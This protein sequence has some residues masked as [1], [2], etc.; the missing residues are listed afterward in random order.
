M[1]KLKS[2][3]GCWSID[4]LILYDLLLAVN[5]DPFYSHVLSFVLIPQAVLNTLS[6]GASL[7]LPPLRERTELLLSLL[8]Q[9][10]QSL[11]ILSKG[12][13]CKLVCAILKKLPM[14]SQSAASYY[15]QMCCLCICVSIQVQYE[16][17]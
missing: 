4:V 11:N 17:C 7:L 12:Q 1:S 15:G 16:K 14:H 13:V 9:G 8:P 10:P 5:A 2:E 3:L 6:I